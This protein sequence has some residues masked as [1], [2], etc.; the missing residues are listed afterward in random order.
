MEPGRVQ[1]DLGSPQDMEGKRLQ[2]DIEERI[3]W[4]R[5]IGNESFPSQSFVS[6]KRKSAH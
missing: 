6:R 2:T 5:A 3:G 1:D 4:F